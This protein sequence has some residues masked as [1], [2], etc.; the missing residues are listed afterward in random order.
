MGCRSLPEITGP[1]VCW[2]LQE[3][4]EKRET[5]TTSIHWLTSQM[6]SV[7]R[8]GQ[9]WEPGTENTVQI[10]HVSDRNSNT[11]AITTA[12]QSQQS[13]KLG[14]RARTWN[15]AEGLW[16]G[17]TPHSNCW[18]QLW[19]PLALILKAESVQ[20]FVQRSSYC[21]SVLSISDC[22]LHRNYCWTLQDIVYVVLQGYV[23]QIS[24]YSH[25]CWMENLLI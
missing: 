13:R 23:L 17:R 12:S 14:S 16:W 10:S 5:E 24:S 11:W 25:V 18:A 15:W 8:A 3:R 21:S 2:Y 19:L 22:S 9:A 7:A 6:L 1:Y 20:I 4:E